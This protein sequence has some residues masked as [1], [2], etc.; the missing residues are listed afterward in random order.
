VAADGTT[1]LSST[2]SPLLGASVRSRAFT[3]IAGNYR[4]VVVAINV[5]GTGAE[6]A[7]SNIVAAR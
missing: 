6:S 5:A 2:V 1:V 4:F 7:R 3:L